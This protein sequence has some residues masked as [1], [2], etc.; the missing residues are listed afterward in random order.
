[1]LFG[2]VCEECL[3]GCSALWLLQT[4]TFRKKNIA[5]NHQDEK[6][7]RAKNNISSNK[8]RVHDFSGS[9]EMTN[10]TNEV[11]TLAQALSRIM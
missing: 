4:P 5:P 3:V 9:Q 8:Q 10:T 1:M 2:C 6:D 11:A 7:Q